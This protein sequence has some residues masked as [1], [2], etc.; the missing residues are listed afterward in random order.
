VDHIHRQHLGNCVIYRVFAH[1][2]LCFVCKQT[3]RH[4]TVSIGQ[5]PLFKHTS[6]AGTLR[7]VTS[8]TAPGASR[9]RWLIDR[10]DANKH[11]CT[12]SW[13]HLLRLRRYIVDWATL[14]YVTLHWPA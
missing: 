4:T 7:S 14:R 10:S 5:I 11:S 12:L 13:R 3:L 8:H 6:N 2:T 9:A 1:K